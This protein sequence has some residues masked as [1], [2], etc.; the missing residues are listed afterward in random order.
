MRHEDANVLG[1][2]RDERQGIHRATAG[3]EEVD[4]STDFPDDPMEVV[5]VLMRR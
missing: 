1:M 3:G 5:G 2:P 4:R